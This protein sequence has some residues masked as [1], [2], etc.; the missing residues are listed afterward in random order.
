MKR[1]PA[2]SV[3]L[4]LLLV[5]T[6]CQGAG[7]Q[8]TQPATGSSTPSASPSA[9]ATALNAEADFER[10][11][12][13]F[14]RGDY[15]TAARLY[16]SAAEH[17]LVAAQKRLA[18]LYGE[19]KGL[20]RDDKESLKWHKLA[21]EQGDSEAHFYVGLIYQYGLGVKQD[22]GE[23]LRW[24]RLAAE[25][26]EP[27]AASAISSLYQEG[28][29]VPLD[30][31]K[32]DKWFTLTGD[33]RVEA[34][35]P[36]FIE[37]C[38][39]VANAPEGPQ[40]ALK[41]TRAAAEAGDP[42]AQA[43]LGTLYLKGFRTVL[44]DDAQAEVWLRRAADKGHAEA[45]FR[46]GTLHYRRSNDSKSYLRKTHDYSNEMEWF[47]KAAEQGH[48]QAQESLGFMYEL[49][50]GVPKD[51]RE[52]S[53]W[54]ARAYRVD[55]ETVLYGRY[56]LDAYMSATELAEADRRVDEWY[57]AQEA[58]WSVHTAIASHSSA[59]KASAENEAQS[60]KQDKVEG[61][62]V[63]LDPG[64]LPMANAAFARGDYAQAARLY[65]PLAEGGDAEAQA[66]LGVMYRDGLGLPQDDDQA[67]LWWN[68]AA[69]QKNVTALYNLGLLNER[70]EG[71]SE[72]N[73]KALRWYRQ[74]AEEGHADAQARLGKIYDFGQGV[75]SDN[76][77]AQKWYRLAAEQGHVEAQLDLATLILLSPIDLTRAEAEVEALEWYRLAADQGHAV[78]IATLAAYYEKG[79]AVPK[80]DAEAARL[81]RRS[82]ELG[83]AEASW[84]LGNLYRHGGGVQKD[85]VAAGMWYRIAEAQGHYSADDSWDEITQ[86]MS[87]AEIAEAEHRADV[88]LGSDSQRLDGTRWGWFPKRPLKK[89]SPA[90]VIDPEVQAAEELSAIRLAAEL[91]DPNARTVLALMHYYG[92]G[93]RQDHAEAARLNGLAA[94][95]GH[96][97][98]QLF[99]ALHYLK[100]DGVQA[101][102]AAAQMWLNVAAALGSKTAHALIEKN[103][104][105][106]NTS[107]VAEAE[108][109][110]EEWMSA[111]RARLKA[112]AA[113][114]RARGSKAEE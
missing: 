40:E 5:S 76:V 34:S 56:R 86:S 81:Y 48:P 73:P 82:A 29:G 96:P 1:L 41:S 9:S 89:P 14:L 36:F 6:A 54:Y 17:G 97:G 25:R 61:L 62:A 22:Y 12:A 85:P 13:A 105:Q 83:H 95:D 80:D 108:R 101:D 79:S 18:H 91:G 26:C 59:P 94:Q 39:Q 46:L 37:Y 52:A 63:T 109:R 60:V 50:R 107:E 11:E 75:P 31:A 78:A 77:E 15:E 30:Q 87:A 55:N 104:E 70:T 3:L 68:Y 69:L 35:N 74:A 112:K 4:A 66:Q 16:R 88:W 58:R 28:W 100:G 65:W 21:A 38:R 102:P 110:A 106:L 71:A 57:R 10:G 114:Y 99:L 103:A 111:F 32:S 64:A 49:G 92:E 72:G 90:K 93:V 27:D 42:Q 84:S 20:Q 33:W 51:G 8:S 45:Q 98:A 7:N 113:A 44:K 53:K 2:I 47:R 67:W 43:I 23:A 19:G 24:Y